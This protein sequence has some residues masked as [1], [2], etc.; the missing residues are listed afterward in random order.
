MEYFTM[1]LIQFRAVLV[2]RGDRLLRW[3]EVGL[4]M[5]LN[6]EARAR[7]SNFSPHMADRVYY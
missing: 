1:A 5:T 3:G 4:N 6:A 2:I 7:Y